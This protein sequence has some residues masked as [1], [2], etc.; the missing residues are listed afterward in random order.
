M[1]D[2]QKYFNIFHVVWKYKSLLWKTTCLERPLWLGRRGGLSRQGPLYST[3]LV[4]IKYHWNFI[5]KCFIFS[6]PCHM[7]PHSAIRDFQRWRQTMWREVCISAPSFSW[8]RCTM[9]L[10]IR[11]RTS[12]YIARSM[13]VFRMTA[14]AWPT[15]TMH[16]SRPPLPLPQTYP[17]TVT[18]TMVTRHPRQRPQWLPAVLVPRCPTSLR[19]ARHR[20]RT[21][22]GLPC[23]NLQMYRRRNHSIE[24]LVVVVDL[25]ICNIFHCCVAVESDMIS[26]GGHW[27]RYIDNTMGY[28]TCRIQH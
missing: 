27:M 9:E 13:S 3:L 19:L 5:F 1:N 2:I 18:V 8:V 26:F 21:K 14:S 12:S 17:R 10:W 7:L 11:R 16:A 20:R 28:L 25:N 22:K 15:W 4:D 6:L 23:R 24:R